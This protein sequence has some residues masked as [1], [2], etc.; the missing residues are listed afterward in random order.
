MEAELG[1]IFVNCQRGTVT[2]MA[3]IEMVHT[4]PPTPEVTDSATGEGFVNENIHQRRSR[5]VYMIFYWVRDR[6]RQGN[7]LVYWMAGEQ[8]MEDY[9]TKLHPPATIEHSGAYI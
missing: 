3:L 6:G 2:C 5:D 1:Y 8:N 7:F 4:H 9:F